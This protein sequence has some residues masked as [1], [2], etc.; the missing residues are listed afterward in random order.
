MKAALWGIDISFGVLGTGTE[1]PLGM[2]LVAGALGLAAIDTTVG[3]PDLAMLDVAALALPFGEI[4][5]IWR[6]AVEFTQ[7]VGEAV[8]S[9]QGAADRAASSYAFLTGQPSAEEQCAALKA[10]YEVSDGTTKI[11]TLQ[12]ARQGGCAW[13][14]GL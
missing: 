11:L 10:A 6:G 2:A 5:L 7:A 4:Y 8:E 13:A 3:R 1:F 12:L 14:A 9:V